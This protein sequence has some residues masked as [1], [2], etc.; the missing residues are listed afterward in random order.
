MS[1]DK[2]SSNQGVIAAAIIAAI[3]AIIAA[4]IGAYAVLVAAH[5]VPFYSSISFTATPGP[6]E[7]PSPI[8]Q[9]AVSVS[10][11]AGIWKGTINSEDGTTHIVAVYSIQSNCT[12]GEMCGTY[13]TPQLGCE[14]NLIF[15]GIGGTAF[16]FIEIKTSGPSYCMSN[17][18]DRFTLY[19]N[20][21]L[22][23]SYSLNGPQGNYLSSGVLSKQ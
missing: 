11:I 14:G 1:E 16:E 15:N 5:V 23:T 22:G 4:I 2:K 3:A 9:S 13:A 20:G 6:I 10:D 8:S 12:I 21:Q 7:R 18:I 19:S 17:G